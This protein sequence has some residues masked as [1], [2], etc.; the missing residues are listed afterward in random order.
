M[1]VLNRLLITSDPFLC[2]IRPKPPK[3][4]KPFKPE[5]IK[6]LVSSQSEEDDTHDEAEIDTDDVSDKEGRNAFSY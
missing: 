5:T 2:C 1:D 6:M 3:K 4:L